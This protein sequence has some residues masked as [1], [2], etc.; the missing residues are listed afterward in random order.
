MSPMSDMILD[1]IIHTISDR[2]GLHSEL[3][4][5]ILF[6]GIL[7]W[8]EEAKKNQCSRR[9]YLEEEAKEVRLTLES[10]FDVETDLMNSDLKFLEDQGS[11]FTETL[12]SGK[13]PKAIVNSIQSFLTALER[14]EN[15]T[16]ESR[17]HIFM[18]AHA[19]YDLE[20]S[21]TET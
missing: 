3:V 4:E 7:D 1:Q 5:K 9:K 2:T 15:M 16:N 20:K 21:Q 14:A 10:I 17:D 11:Q 6:N 13:I 18:V 8:Y 12:S 19:L